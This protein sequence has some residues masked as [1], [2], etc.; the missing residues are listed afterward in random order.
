MNMN[1]TI[2]LLKQKRQKKYK[3]FTE[4]EPTSWKKKLRKLEL[5]N[6]DLKIK[7]EKLKSQYE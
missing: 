6:I 5:D 1:T 3:D 7:I 2:L 4:T